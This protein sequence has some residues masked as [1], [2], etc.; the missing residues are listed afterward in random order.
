MAQD[1]EDKLLFVDGVQIVSY[2]LRT[3]GLFA[4]RSHDE[5]VHVKGCAGD[6]LLGRQICDVDHFQEQNACNF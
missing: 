1:L 3:V 6:V 4:Q 5:G 2:S